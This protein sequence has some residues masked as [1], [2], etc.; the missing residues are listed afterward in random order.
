M[1]QANGLLYSKAFDEPQHIIIEI[2]RGIIA[3][4]LK[5]VLKLFYHSLE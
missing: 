5:S 2:K 4:A 3:Y 1:Q